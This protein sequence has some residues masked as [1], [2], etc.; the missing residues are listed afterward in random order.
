MKNIDSQNQILETSVLDRLIA[1]ENPSVLCVEYPELRSEIIELSETIS[2]A[3]SLPKIAAPRAMKQYKFTQLVSAETQALPYRFIDFFQFTRY[4]VIPI[5]LI[6]ILL[7]SKTMISAT[8]NSLPGEKLYSVKRAVEEA[9]LSLTQDKEKIAMI[10]IELLEKRLDEVKK[11]IQSSDPASE[12]AA[13]VALQNQVNKAYSE[14]PDIAAVNAITKQNPDLLQTL[15]AYNKEQK[16]LFASIADENADLKEQANEILEK[17]AKNEEVLQKIIAVVNEQAKDDAKPTDTDSTSATS[18]S[19]AKPD[20]A[21]DENEPTQTASET[22]KPSTSKPTTST[23]NKVKPSDQTE[24]K[25]TT[26]QANQ[27]EQ[28][29]PNTAKAG[30]IVETAEKQYTE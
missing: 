21:G 15:V 24:P 29:K 16:T 14:V 10:H 5:S 8:Q 6:L 28:I 30:F 27:P 1:G 9:R 13:F 2:L 12:T 7:G 3:Y 11:A 4:A 22:S 18:A 23:K 17:T 20:E 19:A 26:E 25:P